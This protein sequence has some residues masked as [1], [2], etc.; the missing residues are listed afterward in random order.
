MA[1]SI[2]CSTSSVRFAA[3]PA[4]SVKGANAV[5]RSTVFGSTR[6]LQSVS[7]SRPQRTA[8]VVRASEDQELDIAANKVWPSASYSNVYEDIVENLRPLLFKPEA[9][10]DMKVSGVMSTEL[11]SASP[12]APLSTITKYFDAG[13]VSGVPVLDPEGRCVGMLSKKDVGSDASALVK[14]KMTTPARVI[15][16][17]RK[18]AD[19]AAVM[20][21]YKIHRL[22]V[23]DDSERIIGMVTRTDIFT[24]LGMT[25]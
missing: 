15:G 5:A 18:V 10:P 11:I 19:A 1:S 4:S 9:D 16:C 23:K 14:S 17:D 13:K 3:K 22:P 7:F 6:H 25:V 12:D 21:K 24:A 8:L 2:A 20:L